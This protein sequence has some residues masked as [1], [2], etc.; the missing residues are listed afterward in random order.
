MGEH[1]GAAVG[2]VDLPTYRI[3]PESGTRRHRS[4]LGT[5]GILLFVC[6]FLPAMRGCGTAPVSPLDVPP[7]LPP[8]LFGLV[9]AIMA[10]I[11]S[12]RAV[13]AG[14]IAVRFL[15]MLVALV[16]FMVFLIAPSVG[17]VELTVGMV[18]LTTIGVSG[19][20]ETR[21]AAA[22]VIVGLVCTCWFGLWTASV[23]ALYGV[24]LSLVSS[25]G[26]LIGGVVWLV[27]T[28]I[29]PSALVPRAVVRRR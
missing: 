27:E 24:H 14:V 21:L 20:S 15:A 2:A 17:I 28:V 4:V 19:V 3:F 11:R 6:M 22:T 7:F 9:F 10:S 25:I 29:Y 12:S 26:L 23:D 13:F 8:Y 16:G 18:L 1:P 5:A